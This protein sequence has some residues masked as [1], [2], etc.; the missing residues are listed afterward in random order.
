MK[1][2]GLTLLLMMLSTS[3]V[4]AQDEDTFIPQIGDAPIASRIQISA[5]N[6]DG[7][8]TITGEAGAVYPNADVAIRNLYTDETVIGRAAFDGSFTF[9]L[10][11]QDET[12]YWI[13]PSPSIPFAIRDQT[14]FIPGGPATIVY[15]QPESSASV[16]QIQFDGELAGWDFYP[17]AQVAEGIYLLKNGNSLYFTVDTA[18][19]VDIAVISLILDDVPFALTIDTLGNLTTFQPTEAEESELTE[20]PFEIQTNSIFEARVDVSSWETD[21]VIIESVQ[22]IDSSRPVPQFASVDQPLLQLDEAEGVVYQPNPLREDFE[23]FFIG[24]V[25]PNGIRWQAVGRINQVAFASGD[26]LV[27]DLDVTMNAPNVAQAL[28]GLQLGGT[29]TLH[30]FFDSEGQPISQGLYGGFGWSSVRTETDLPISNL[31][32]IRYELGTAIA[33]TNY[34]TQAGTTLQFGLQFRLP[35]PDDLPYGLYLPTFAGAVRVSDGDWETWD[36]SL[37]LSTQVSDD[38]IAET[39]LPPVLRIGDIETPQLPTGYWLNQPNQGVR[40]IGKLASNQIGWQRY[41]DFYQLL[42]GNYPVTPFVF[43]MMSNRYGDEDA[44]AIQ[45]DSGELS[46]R[47]SS[48][49]GFGAEFN[50]PITQWSI[51]TDNLNDTTQFGQNAPVNLPSLSSNQ[52]S[53]VMTINSTSEIAINGMIEDRW[54]NT[55]RIEDELLFLPAQTLLIQPAVLTGTPFE[56]GDPFSPNLRLLPAIPATVIEV[57]LTIYPL[58]GSEPIVQEWETGTYAF[59]VFQTDTPF[60]IPVSGTYVTDY[61]AQQVIDSQVVWDGRL[62]TIGVIANP[63]SELIVHGQRGVDGYDG[64]G[65]AWF[66]T[67]VYPND[68]P[69]ASQRPYYPYFSG[70]V[71]FIPD[72]ADSGIVPF[73]TLQDTS[74]KYQTWLTDNNLSQT[75]QNRAL[76]NSLPLQNSETNRAYGVISAVRPD[77]QLRQLILGGEG[78]TPLAWDGDDPF[79]QQT[80]AGIDGNRAGD[81][82]F[83][84]GGVIVQNEDAGVSD[85]N[86]YASLAIVTDESQPARVVPPFQGDGATLL[87]VNNEAFSMFFHPT[88]ARPGQVL[89]LGERLS[90]IGQVAPTLPA[91]VRVKITSPTGDVTRFDDIANAIGY[92]YSP[93]NDLIVDEIGAWQVEIT[94]EFRGQTSAEQVI[95]PFPS[96]GVLGAI[97]DAFTVYVVDDSPRLERLTVTDAVTEFSPGFNQILSVVAPENWTNLQATY[98]LS[99]ASHLITE[100]E[101]PFNGRVVNY[102][103]N[104]TQLSRQLPNYEGNLPNAGEWVSDTL[105]LTIAIQGVDENGNPSMHVR[106]FTILHD[107]VV[108]FD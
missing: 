102:T 93:E 57:R 78:D 97:E 96:G 11:G 14:D 35:I 2:I 30:P 101:L 64:V 69:N 13:S 12:P 58:D 55:Y 37:V 41:T 103:F 17:S 66:D 105:L 49:D 88:G 43:G 99:T 28:D 5:P 25:L 27:L 59:G 4:V 1:Q 46:I 48:L 34:V 70:D 20:L 75:M 63:E 62:R 100:G 108:S 9:Q 106:Q 77:I 67:T 10:L 42:P 51:G 31:E 72:T 7:I 79:N 61:R 107:K 98:S 91:K 92:F 16:L 22:V 95:A 23:R 50:D 89:M 38:Q 76:L 87:T 3:L 94:T 82:A 24:D 15:G 81:F 18:S 90:I 8:V 71:A 39:R 60:V 32:S 44:P 80:G 33:D 53:Q 73:L 84:F 74:G 56:V 65:L 47:I 54:G 36:N 26:E 29:L 19:A 6:E 83:L 40:G 68:E 85:A 21:D 104:P 45:L 52:I 86:I